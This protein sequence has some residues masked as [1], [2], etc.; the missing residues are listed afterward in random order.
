MTRSLSKDTEIKISV[1]DPEEISSINWPKTNRS[2]YDSKI[3]ENDKRIELI[4]SQLSND[5]SQGIVISAEGRYSSIDLKE[6]INGFQIRMQQRGIR[7]QMSEQIDPD[8]SGADLKKFIVR[9]IGY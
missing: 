4:L 1:A 5:G 7:V 9:K 8:A 3:L 6:Y 2:S